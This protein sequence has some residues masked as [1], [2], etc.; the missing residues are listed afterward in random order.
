MGTDPKLKEN[1]AAEKFGV[2]VGQ[3]LI[4]VHPDKRDEVKVVGIEKPAVV[5]FWARVLLAHRNHAT[6]VPQCSGR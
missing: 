3:Q 6:P 1:S 2:T 5:E 4:V